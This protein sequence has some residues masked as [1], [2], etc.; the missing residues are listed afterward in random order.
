MTILQDKERLIFSSGILRLV[1]YGLLL[2]AIVDIFFLLIPPQLM[3]PVWE[4]ETMGTI[5]ERIPITLLGMV[6]VYYGERS[7]RAPIETLLL[8]VASWLSL[9]AAILLLLMIPLSINNGFRIYNQQKAQVNAQ[10]VSQKD[11]II[12][13][14]DRLKLANSQDEIKNILQQQAKQQ[15]N[16]PD[17]VDTQKLKTDIIQK[18]QTNQKNITSQVDLFK[19]QKRTFILKK[20]L[21]WNLGGLI[22]SI[23]FFLIWKSTGWARI[24]INEE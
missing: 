2:M 20:C 17:T 11:A 15:I 8:K 12:E 10:F 22:S 3:N 23:L 9:V 14:E 1:G 6:L 18:L 19:K 13:Y 7:D 16:I 4:F 21:R 5:V 24:Q